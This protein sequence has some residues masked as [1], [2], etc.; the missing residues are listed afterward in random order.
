[1]DNNLLKALQGMGFTPV[2]G[3][4]DMIF[5]DFGQIENKVLAKIAGDMLKAKAETIPASKD[6]HIVALTEQ[7]AL[8]TDIV[9]ALIQLQ[10]DD[11]MEQLKNADEPIYRPPFYPND[12][13]TYGTDYKC[14]DDEVASLVNEVMT[15]VPRTA[16]VV[17]AGYGDTNVIKI[18]EEDGSYAVYVARGYEE[19][20]VEADGKIVD[21]NEA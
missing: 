18:V 4:H 17:V 8:L 2:N 21:P 3:P 5:V 13:Y 16:K 11:L 10:T 9:N 12:Y 19:L 20:L 7:V 15:D 6:E 14:S 1:M